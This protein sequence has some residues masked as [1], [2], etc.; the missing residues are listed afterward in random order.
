MGGFWRERV[1]PRRGGAGWSDRWRVDSVD[2]SRVVVVGGGYGG[3]RVAKELDAVADVTLV[4]PKDAFVHAV[5]ALRAAVDASWEDRIFFSYD[6]LL[7]R[8]SSR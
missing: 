2:K 1:R 4:E 6:H 7:T 8:V 5:G 3:S